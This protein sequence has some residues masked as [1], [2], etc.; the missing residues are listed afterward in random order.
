MSCPV[1]EPLKKGGLNAERVGSYH[2][3]RILLINC[4]AIGQ[5]SGVG[6]TLASLFRGWPKD[7]IAQIIPEGSDPDKSIC[8]QN[9][10]LR[11]PGGKNSST[12]NGKFTAHLLMKLRNVSGYPLTPELLRW[13]CEF[14]PQLIYSF[15]EVPLITNLVVR[16]AGRL[17][18]KIIPHIMDEWN[19]VKKG[20]RLSEYYWHFRQKMDFKKILKR[21]T[22]GLSIS[23]AMSAEY[24]KRYQL[25]FYTF[26]NSAAPNIYTSM[27]QKVSA[28]SKLRMAYTGAGAGLGR[29]PIIIN[30]AK[31]V[32]IL[33]QNGCQIEFTAF[34]RKE[35]FK[36]FPSQG[37]GFTIVNFMEEKK[38]A[39]FLSHCD[40]AVLAEGFD[41][42]S[43]KYTRLSF[44]SKIPIYLMSGCYILAIGPLQN[45][46]IQ[47][48]EDNKLGSTVQ[49]DSL[50]V[51][52]HNLKE[53]YCNK[54]ILSDFYLRNRQFSLEHHNQLS[55]HK[56]LVTL[57]SCA[58]NKT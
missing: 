53:L 21:S 23:D 24:F 28:T 26:M 56:E 48:V 54:Q 1:R 43:I 30:L 57:F 45:N 55:I 4:Q 14:R 12:D 9:W 49:E 13:V 11:P 37:D 36:E 6:V 27:Q 29:W 40:I 17:N 7:R 34:V 3:P 58:V 5:K 50:E 41:Q 10:F 46:S 47:Y 32:Q 33:N 2:Y 38:L 19:F 52:L 8:N 44:S 18:V 16:L 39:A 20:S 42:E 25:P 31:A 15:L 35:L 51:L 22:F